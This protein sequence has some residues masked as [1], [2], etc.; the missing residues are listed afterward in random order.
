VLE[1]SRKIFRNARGRA[2]RGGLSWHAG[3]RGGGTCRSRSPRDH[4][5]LKRKMDGLG[6]KPSKRV[7]AASAS[8]RPRRMLGIVNSCSRLEVSVRTFKSA[9]WLAVYGLLLAPV[10]LYAAGVDEAAAAA[11]T[12]QGLDVN[13]GASGVDIALK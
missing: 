8:C 10:P 11:T 3:S 13:L 4:R 7:L 2:N 9:R 6:A 5:K 12:T 1:H